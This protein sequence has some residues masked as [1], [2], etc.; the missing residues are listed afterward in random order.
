M[1]RV[2]V[3]I[4]REIVYW[5]DGRDWTN[6]SGCNTTMRSKISAVPINS[7]RTQYPPIKA[8]RRGNIK[9][10][11]I[12]E[13]TQDMD[14]YGFCGAHSGLIHLD[15]VHLKLSYSKPGIV[16]L[17]LASYPKL[18]TLRLSSDYESWWLPTKLFPLLPRSLTHLQA[19]QAVYTSHQDANYLE[20]VPQLPSGLLTLDMTNYNMNT[21]SLALLPKSLTD[22]TLCY[23]TMILCN[24]DMS[25]LPRGLEHLCIRGVSRLTSACIAHVPSSL[26]S[27]TLRNLGYTTYPQNVWSPSLHLSN[28]Q[29]FVAPT[30]HFEHNHFVALPPCLNKLDVS[31]VAESMQPDTFLFLPRSLTSL[32]LHGRVT[33][34]RLHL[35]QFPSSLCTL[36]L[37]ESTD[38]E[39]ALSLDALPRQL[40]NLS[41]SPGN[42]I[43]DAHLSQLPR[44]LQFLTLNTNH[45][46]TNDGME[47]LPPNLF[48]LGIHANTNLTP[49]CLPHLPRSLRRLLCHYRCFNAPF[50]KFVQDFGNTDKQ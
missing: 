20:Y 23:W 47:H 38:S 30:A 21:D 33:Y 16:D 14:W 34:T 15:L 22:L 17:I 1:D 43:K 48:E 46:I 45:L 37:D 32:Q 39:A 12:L 31:V 40:T 2:C 28:L 49:A 10:I 24:S 50:T 41:L 5:L 7:V 11:T 6:L 27:L 8:F 36:H 25:V 19:G 18:E 35:K 3:D 29:V 44:S 42:C 26:K 4:L 9:T 13:Q